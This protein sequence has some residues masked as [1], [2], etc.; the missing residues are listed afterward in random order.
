LY[1]LGRAQF[2]FFLAEN[3]LVVSPLG[4]KQSMS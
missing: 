4:C 3:S 2:A 1:Q